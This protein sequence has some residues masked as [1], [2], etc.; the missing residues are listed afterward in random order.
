MLHFG[1]PDAE[2]DTAE[3]AVRRGMGITADEREAGQRDALF[4]AHDVD[5]SM[6][7]VRHREMR[8]AEILCR[9][10]QDF[11]GLPHLA[12]GYILQDFCRGRDTVVRRA[13]QLVRLADLQP[14][15]LEHAKGAEMQ[16]VDEVAVDIE[17]HVAIRA[18]RD[19]MLVPNF[20]EYRL[21]HSAPFVSHGEILAASGV[22]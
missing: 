10:L 16:V 2:G 4:R 15:R 11:D 5:D 8:E 12:F 3:R 7:F 20:F 14:L 21:A 19:D 17:Q 13:E 1:R 22:R 6:S 18:R 9:L